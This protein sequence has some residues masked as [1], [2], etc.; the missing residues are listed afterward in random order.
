MEILAIIPARGGSKGLPGKNIRLLSGH[1]LI[2]Y[3]ILA[4]QKSSKINRIIVSTDSK[5][6]AEISEKYGAEVPFIRPANLAEDNSKDIE[7]FQH[8]L[9]FLKEKENYFPD[10]VIQLRPTSPIRFLDDI[11]NCINLLKNNADADSVRVVTESPITPY[12]M[13]KIKDENSPMEPL[14]EIEDIIEPYNE[15]RH[16]LPKVYWQVGVLDVI[17]TNII[18]EKNT[19]SGN[20]ILP[21]IINREYSVD[22]DNVKDF[23]NAEIV[24]NNSKCIKFN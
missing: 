24:I 16:T 21:Y 6:I 4:A 2:S 20:K 7:V 11:D 15:S 3:S 12:K 17:R 9:N 23:E 8:A 10:F 14:L 18:N 1:P 22:I 13:W 19:M 5:E